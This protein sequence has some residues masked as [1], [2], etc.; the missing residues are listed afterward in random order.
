MFDLSR[1]PIIGRFFRDY[2]TDD[3]SLYI[4]DCIQKFFSKEFKYFNV[5]DTTKTTDLVSLFEQQYKEDTLY[6]FYLFH[7]NQNN[8]FVLKQFEPGKVEGIDNLFKL[9]PN[10]K[11]RSI[12]DIIKKCKDCEQYAAREYKPLFALL[13][14]LVTKLKLGSEEKKMIFG[15]YE[16]GIRRAEILFNAKAF[17][18]YAIDKKYALVT[19]CLFTRGIVLDYILTDPPKSPSFQKIIYFKNCHDHAEIYIKI[20][21]Q[22]PIKIGKIKYSRK[23]VS[24]FAPDKIVYNRRSMTYTV[25]G[26]KYHYYWIKVDEN[27]EVIDAR[28]L[29]HGMILRGKYTDENSWIILF[30]KKFNYLRTFSTKDMKEA[31]KKVNTSKLES[32]KV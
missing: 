7:D 32:I 29:Q 2:E 9:P 22:K 25:E 11:Q 15:L 23:F 24:P 18:N 14:Y 1:I 16:Q 12:E 10:E 26:K 13:K 28:K 5:V 30:D 6:H 21:K 19:V 4:L 27:N 3:Y 17:S 8:R 20:Y 31:E